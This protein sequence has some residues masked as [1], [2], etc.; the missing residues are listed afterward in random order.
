[1]IS[2][3]TPPCRKFPSFISESLF[4][5]ISESLF[6]DFG[7][8]KFLAKQH[9]PVVGELQPLAAVRTARFSTQTLRSHVAL[10]STGVTA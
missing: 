10:R 1:M 4:Q 9:L 5:D 6:Q 7:Q 2:P 3:L 8:R